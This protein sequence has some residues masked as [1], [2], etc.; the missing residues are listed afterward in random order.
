[1]ISI[2]NALVPA[3]RRRPSEPRTEARGRARSPRKAEAARR[4][5]GR[6]GFP[7]DAW[8]VWYERQTL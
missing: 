8:A 5:E 4:D 7:C 3:T 2:V 1:M 6:Y